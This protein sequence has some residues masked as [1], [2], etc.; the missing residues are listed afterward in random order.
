MVDNR[1]VKVAII[2]HGAGSNAGVARL[3]LPPEALGCDDAVYLDD[4]TGRIE[5][6]ISAIDDTFAQRFAEGQD[7]LV[8]GIS[9]GAHA[10]AMWSA[11]RAAVGASTSQRLVL[12]L[13]AWTGGPDAVAAATAAS[14][15]DI[16]ARGMTAVLRE[17]QDMAQ[18][19]QVPRV[20]VDLVRRGW[21]AYDAETLAQ[22]LQNAADSPGPSLEELRS[23]RAATTVVTWPDD[24]LHP[25]SVGQTW[26]D[27][28]DNAARTEINWEELS[29]DVQAFARTVARSL[30][31]TGG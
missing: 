3:L 24:A 23:I 20:V 4:R 22:V 31:L 21:T 11:Q 17:L 13:P 18:L 12:A 5:D 29:A 25:E 30:A 9:L 8:A 15:R 1:D 26:A 6:V 16:R 7:L 27:A 19:G 10:A 2:A 14:A 28:I